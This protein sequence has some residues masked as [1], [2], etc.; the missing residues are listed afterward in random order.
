MTTMSCTMTR[1]KCFNDTLSPDSK[2][3]F[4]FLG[5]AKGEAEVFMDTN[6]LPA[7][8][9]LSNAIQEALKRTVFLIIFLGRSYPNSASQSPRSGASDAF[10]LLFSLFPPIQGTTMSRGGRHGA[11]QNRSAFPQGR[12]APAF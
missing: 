1:F 5:S 7:N 12:D 2:L 3:S 11:E 8:G 6:G 9:D 10:L 4:D